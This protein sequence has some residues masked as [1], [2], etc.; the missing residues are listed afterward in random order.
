[1]I[2]TL[3]EIKVLLG[4]S[5]TSKDAQITAL[6]P[7]VEDDLLTYCNNPFESAIATW[8]GSVTPTQVPGLRR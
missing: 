4:I 1:M 5:D 2:A 7:L 8:A 3:A 6:I